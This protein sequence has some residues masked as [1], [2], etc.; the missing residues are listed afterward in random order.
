LEPR[1][2]TIGRILRPHGN[3][4]DVRVWSEADSPEAF[5]S[6]LKKPVYLDRKDLAPPGLIEVEEA[7]VH[8]G[9]ILVKIKGIEDIE[10]AESLR[11]HLM[12][13]REEDR[14]PLG[15]DEFYWDQLIGLEV[16]DS[17]E[18]NLIGQVKDILGLG[19]NLLLEIEKE[20]GKTFLAP[21]ARKTIASVD[22]GKG[23]IR[24]RLPEG[25]EDL[26][27]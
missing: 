27:S 16:R 9:F 11:D 19:G 20:G 5:F 6:F 4:G 22:L 8:K 26:S 13:I 14:D 1:Y 17:I 21:F 10:A 23:I 25:L 7:K 18:G 2:V 15:E 24:S 3:K 12:V